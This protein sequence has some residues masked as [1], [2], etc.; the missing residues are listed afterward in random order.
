MAT[1]WQA[2]LHPFGIGAAPSLLSPHLH[3]AFTS[4]RQT[5][6]DQTRMQYSAAAARS[7]KKN[8]GFVILAAQIMN[9]VPMLCPLAPARY[10]LSCLNEFG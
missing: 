9:A 10:P 5:A 6:E 8:E 2:E 3:T 7:H 1:G 4:V